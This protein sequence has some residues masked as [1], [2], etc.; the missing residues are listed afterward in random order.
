MT[1]Y[2][3][4]YNI[5]RSIIYGSIRAGQVLQQNI[6]LVKAIADIELPLPGEAQLE[7]EGALPQQKQKLDRVTNQ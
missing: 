3:I 1:S 7:R 2:A 5:K 4:G 6:G